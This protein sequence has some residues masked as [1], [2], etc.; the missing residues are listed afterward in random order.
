MN[1]P[2]DLLIIG[3]G[4]NGPRI[5]RDAAAAAC[6]SYCVEKDDLARTYLVG[7]HQA[8]PRRPAIS[9]AIRI[10]AGSEALREREVL[11]G[12]APH[13]IWPL[14]FV[15]P[16]DRA[17]A[18]ALDAADWGCFSTIISAA[19]VRCPAAREVE[20]DR[21][22]PSHGAAGSP[23]ARFRLFGLLGGG[24]EAGRPQRARRARKRGGHTHALRDASGSNVCTDRW[25][26][27][28]R[29]RDG[30]D[31]SS[32]HAYWSMP[33]VHGSTKWRRWPWG[34]GPRRICG[35]SRAATS[36]CRANTPAIMPISSSSPTSAS[37]SRSPTSATT[38]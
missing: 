37:S 9:R 13:I 10:P 8:D 16:Y 31:G 22:A 21:S 27:V 5:A 28:L 12:A 2:L 24:C 29:D 32:K 3:G 11:L 38:R 36:S 17:N 14:R 1:D 15:L 35:W 26:A 34:R 20:S 19:A 30:A 4:V 33:R 7:Q 6:R 25:R 23:H 18:S